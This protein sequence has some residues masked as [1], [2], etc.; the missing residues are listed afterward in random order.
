MAPQPEQ[1]YGGR[2][3]R[4]H[5]REPHSVPAT[6]HPASGN[7]DLTEDV[8]VSDLSI[9]GVG[10]I[11][12]RR[13]EKDSFWRITLGNGPLYL[14]AKLRVVCCRDRADGRYDVGCEFC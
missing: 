8:M 6:L 7:T 5:P 3:R 9:G 4:R 13:F 10:L 12:G 11:C 14:N 1:Q 2:E